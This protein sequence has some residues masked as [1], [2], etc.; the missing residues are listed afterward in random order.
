MTGVGML[1]ITTSC[2]CR[3]KFPKGARYAHILRVPRVQ[4][5]KSVSADVNQLGGL[6]PQAGSKTSFFHF[7]PSRSFPHPSLCLPHVPPPS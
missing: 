4:T 5:S 6:F 3:K 2:G 7:R 1:P